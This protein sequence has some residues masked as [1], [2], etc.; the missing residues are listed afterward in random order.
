MW[1]LDEINYYKV[2]ITVYG[3]PGLDVS[4]LSFGSSSLLYKEE[5]QKATRQKN[6]YYSTIVQQCSLV[7]EYPRHVTLIAH[8]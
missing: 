1:V 5:T 7:K 6:R 4:A 3:I 8:Y 2:N